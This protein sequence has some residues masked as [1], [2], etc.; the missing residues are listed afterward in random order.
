MGLRINA[1]ESAAKDDEFA[2]HYRALAEVA[3]WPWVKWWYKRKANKL[4]ESADIWRGLEW[5]TQAAIHHAMHHK[6]PDA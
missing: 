4:E 3:K 6:C 5:R 2:A 1:M